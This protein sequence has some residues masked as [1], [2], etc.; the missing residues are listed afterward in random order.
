MKETI[1]DHLSSTVF[2]K[3]KDDDKLVFRSKGREFVEIMGK[4]LRKPQKAIGLPF[5]TE[6]AGL[7]NNRCQTLRAKAL[8]YSLK[9]DPLKIP[10]L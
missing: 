3:T 8:D 6:R 9:K 4:G 7:P 10:I 5:R 2:Q 1:S